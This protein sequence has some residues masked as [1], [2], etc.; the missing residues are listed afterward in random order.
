MATKTTFVVFKQHE[1][2]SVVDLIGV[3]GD[4]LVAPETLKTQKDYFLGA[5]QL[6]MAPHRRFGES[7][8]AEIFIFLTHKRR[9]VF[10]LVIHVFY[11][12]FLSENFG[13]KNA[14]VGGK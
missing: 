8:V 11:T 4:P 6:K 14:S 12:I 3:A 7:I 9:D 10:S 5:F 2:Q 13:V 1:P